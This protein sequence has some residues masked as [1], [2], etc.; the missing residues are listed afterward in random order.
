[1]NGIVNED[2]WRNLASATDERGD[3]KPAFEAAADKGFASVRSTYEGR[4][5]TYG[6]TWS[7]VDGLYDAD[8][9]R[10]DAWS[11]MRV[12]LLRMMYT[13]GEHRDSIVDMIAYSCAYLQWMDEGAVGEEW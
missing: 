8:Q 11:L 10:A 5:R 6:S 3:S 12:K 9:R 1:M 7:L 13:K 4:G 2:F